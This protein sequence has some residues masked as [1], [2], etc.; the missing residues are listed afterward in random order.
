VARDP[1]ES[2]FGILGFRIQRNRCRRNRDFA[3][4]DRAEKEAVTWR[5]DHT[6]IGV[7]HFG[8]LGDEK[9]TTGEV[10]KSRNA[11]VPQS[12]QVSKGQ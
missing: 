5:R 7:R 6:C 1:G 11:T 2:G 3:I 8:I 9:L 12:K 10:A 4:P